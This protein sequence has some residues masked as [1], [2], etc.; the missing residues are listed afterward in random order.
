MRKSLAYSRDY[1]ILFGQEASKETTEKVEKY[2]KQSGNI[3][4]WRS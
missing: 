3:Q 1:V 2:R 4:D